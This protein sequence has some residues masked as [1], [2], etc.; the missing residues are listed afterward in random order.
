VSL[1]LFLEMWVFPWSVIFIWRLVS[2]QALLCFISLKLSTLLVMF[3]YT[4]EVFMQIPLDFFLLL[5]SREP[6][7][8]FNAFIIISIWLGKRDIFATSFINIVPRFPALLPRPAPSPIAAHSISASS[9]LPFPLNDRQQLRSVQ[10]HFSDY[11]HLPTEGTSFIWVFPLF[12]ASGLRF[13]SEDWRR[14]PFEF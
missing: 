11:A 10:L 8:F 4:F 6:W 14:P 7:H 3:N 13:L 5:V 9:I 2:Y 1:K 12:F